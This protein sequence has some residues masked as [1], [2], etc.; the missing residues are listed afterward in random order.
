MH[1]HLT[2]IFI[3]A[4]TPL[5]VTITTDEQ[6]RWYTFEPVPKLQIGAATAAGQLTKECRIG[7]IWLQGG[8]VPIRAYGVCEQYK[9]AL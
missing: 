1:A 7:L 8:A 5:Q 3:H 6:N 9:S 2:H 4:C